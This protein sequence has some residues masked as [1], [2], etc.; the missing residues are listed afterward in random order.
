L[1]IRQI[2]VLEP[3]MRARI[4]DCRQKGFDGVEP[5]EIDGYEN[6]TGFPLTHSDQLAYNR[7][8][9]GWVH[10][11]GLSVGLKGDI[12]QA[13]EL[14]PSF[15]WTL[16]EECFRYDEC[17]LLDVFIRAG[18]AVWI[19]EYREEDLSPERC[20]AAEQHA[21]NAARYELGLPIDGGRRPCPAA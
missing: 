5:D 2:D 6:E 21:W 1:D 16:N 7:A 3:I 20:D 13:A 18:K 19:A 17:E 8:V 14:E 10:E 4:D 12:E 15:D 11:A 9:A